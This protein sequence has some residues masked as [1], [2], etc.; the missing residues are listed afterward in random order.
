MTV[1]ELAFGGE[2]DVADVALRHKLKQRCDWPVLGRAA[3]AAAGSAAGAAARGCVATEAP[4][5][6]DGNRRDAPAEVVRKPNAVHSWT[7][8]RK[9][10]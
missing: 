7:C 8:R 3:G 9:A 10:L 4:H 2:R 1:Y 6:N 5:G